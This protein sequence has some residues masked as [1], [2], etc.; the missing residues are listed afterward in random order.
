MVLNLLLNI[1]NKY[2]AI[3]TIDQMTVAIDNKQSFPQQLLHTTVSNQ[4]LPRC[5]K[6]SQFWVLFNE[7]INMI[8]KN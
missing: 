6:P 2:S 7:V 3:L 4:N 5:N 8:T 1:I